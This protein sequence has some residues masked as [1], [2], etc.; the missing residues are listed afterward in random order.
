M[1]LEIYKSQRFIIL[2]K[3]FIYCSYSSFNIIDK[4]LFQRNS[5]QEVYYFLPTWVSLCWTL[6]ILYNDSEIDIFHTPHKDMI[7]ENTLTY[8]SDVLQ[9]RIS[10]Y[11]NPFLI[12]FAITNWNNKKFIG[13]SLL[14]CSGFLNV[15]FGESSFVVRGGDNNWICRGRAWRRGRLYNTNE[16]F[17]SDSDRDQIKYI[18]SLI[19]RRSILLIRSYLRMIKFDL[20]LIRILPESECKCSIL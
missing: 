9:F 8:Q 20:I 11:H 3:F 14:I 5:M 4:L 19:L 18:Q 15:F 12:F 13:H 10:H 6:K 1:T 16:H 17:C 2:Y 7:H